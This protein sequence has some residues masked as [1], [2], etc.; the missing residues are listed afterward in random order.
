VEAPLGFH[1]HLHILASDGCFHKN[2]MFAGPRIT[3]DK[4]FDQ[5]AAK[6]WIIVDMKRDWKKCSRQNN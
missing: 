6:G 3:L 5:A 2:G 4:A 1:P